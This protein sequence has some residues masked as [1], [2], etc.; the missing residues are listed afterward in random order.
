MDFDKKEKD[1]KPSRAGADFH[2]ELDALL[3]P[4]NLDDRVTEVMDGQDLLEPDAF[5][6]F[7]PD[8]IPRRPGE[9]ERGRHEAPGEEEPGEETEESQPEEK[10]PAMDPN[11]PRYAAPER[12]RVLV[13]ERRPTVYITPEGEFSREEDHEPVGNS[14]GEGRSWMIAILITLAVLAAVLALVLGLVRSRGGESAEESAAMSTPVVMTAAPE[15]PDPGEPETT[16][17]PEPTTAPT[18][19]PKTAKYTIT[20]T[21]GTGGSISPSGTVSVEEGEDV[22][23]A[24]T[25]AAGYELT[26]LLVDGKNADLTNFYTFASVKG[27]HTLYAVFQLMV[28]PTPEPTAEPTPEPTAEPT[29]APTEPPATEP[30]VPEQSEPELPPAESLIQDIPEIG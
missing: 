1:E 21:A 4:W 17:T 19:P 23:F 14:G 16:N 13:A 10:K 3:E 20:V 27:D 24:I 25:P 15:E 11:D 12:P 26:Q 18:E 28:T 22:S 8:Y 2:K 9:N 6:Y 7:A 5:D 30:E 29:P